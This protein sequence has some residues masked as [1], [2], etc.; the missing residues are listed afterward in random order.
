MFRNYIKTAFRSLLRHRFFSFINIFGLAIAMSIC[1]GIIMLVADQMTYDRYNTKRDRI[2]RITSRHVTGD[3]LEQSGN[4]YAT[5][6]LPIKSELLEQYTGIEKAVRIRRGFGNGW[7]EFEQDVNIPLHGFY[8][9]PEVFDVFEY[10]MEYGDA[11]T[12]LTEPYTV[13]LTKQA[14]RKLFK[15]E[16]PLGLTIKVGDIGTY[17]VT[18][19]LK[20]TTRKSHIV[21]EAFASMATLKSKE[22][23]GG[24]FD[25]DNWHHHWNAWT[26]I[27]LEPGKS[28]A[29]L[30]N[31]LEKIYQA[32]IKPVSNPDILK[33]KFHLQALSNVTPGKFMN[34]PIGPFL[35]WIFIYFFAGLAGLVLITSC[36]NFTNLSIA[37][38]LTRAR[39]IGV[40]KVSGAA[41]W[42]IF[43]QF[44]S[45]SILTSLFALALAFVFL[46]AVK[47]LML[48]LTFARVLKWDLESNL[49]VY[50]VFILFA[51][52][53][54]ILAGLFPA[55]VLSGF[56]P[57][58]VLKN[59]GNMKL[60]SKMG[61]R[62]ALLVAQFS[63]SLIFILSVIVVYN[64]LNLFLHADHGFEMKNN[65]M[66][67]LNNTPYQ[68][69]KTELSKY[70]NIVNVSAASHVP[71]AGTTYGEGFKKSLDEKEW[72][73]L[74]YYA[75]DEDYLKN[76][77]MELVAGRNYQAEAGVSN[78]N[79]LVINEEA[80]NA[81]HFN[82][83]LDALGQEVIMQRDSSR[84]QIIGV[85]KN[86]NHEMLMAKI[87]P[88]ALMYS[89][90]QFNILQ[91]KYS[92]DYETATQSIETAWGKINP[93]YKIDY[94][95]FEDEIR[96]FY[97]T[98]FGDLVNIVAVVALLAIVISCLG[99]LGMATYTTETRIKEISIRK[100]LGSSNA[101]LI[102]LLSRGFVKLLMI[103]II[104]AVPLAYLINNAWLELIAYHTSFDVTVIF[105][106]ILVLLV[107]G[108]I[109][110][111]SQ[112][113]RATYVNPVENLKSE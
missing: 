8:A 71:A 82:S 44:I 70:P 18:G 40:R 30:E 2:Y 94:K 64:Q 10:E 102:V 98:V 105:L 19:V 90:E 6:P 76:I 112:T 3:G 39:E 79:F 111:G 86:Y 69:L 62:K 54:G 17:T 1:M 7:I 101:S 85:V 97:D 88:M 14:A 60:F 68:T 95:N 5:S 16:N 41:R 65:I 99:L 38:S 89:E 109:T 87:S 92:G 104:I 73:S 20:E 12:A 22:A 77:G 45:E 110:I 46:V 81:F 49:Y 107:F 93:A 53:V 47:P 28:P 15:E 108:V 34:N 42:Q 58:K 29:E 74:N 35:P 37:R 43:T 55:T 48:T 21:F 32:H 80:V 11:A 78:K 24:D 26:Y 91:V 52:I 103:S 96:S 27:V 23:E 25:L 57:V 84:L 4:D 56:Q 72:T 113:I 67:R 31:H 59:L 61:L 33:A 66:I 50:G 75:V 106:G 9:D 36:F 13:V 83:P 100:I 63:L 51:V